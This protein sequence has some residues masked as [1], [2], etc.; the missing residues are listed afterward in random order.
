MKLSQCILKLLE[1]F[2]IEKYFFR[3][4]FF[5]KIR[6]SQLNSKIFL[7]Q[8]SLVQIRHC[9]TRLY[10]TRLFL[11]KCI[12]V[13]LWPSKSKFLSFMTKVNPNNENETISNVWRHTS[14]CHSMTKVNPNNR[15]EA[16]LDIFR[17]TYFSL[18]AK[19]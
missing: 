13:S 2:S 4:P 12:K 9:L 14:F 1:M 11:S 3:K 6:I 7:K 10:W 16:K 15:N 5:R 19:Y 17:V 8:Q 18:V